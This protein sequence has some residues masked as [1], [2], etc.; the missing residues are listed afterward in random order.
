MS[1]KSF[2]W[3]AGAVALGVGLAATGWAG[4]P[5]PAADD[6][7]MNA[8][9]IEACSC[10]M[11]CQ[12]YFNTAP[13][14]HHEHSGETSHYCRFNNA[15]QVNKGHYGATDL[16]GARFWVAGD[17]GGDFSKGQ[18]DWAA[19]HFDPAVTAAQR[20]GIG[21]IVGY[22]YPVKWNSFAMGEDAAM[23]WKASK[24]RAE[25]RMDGGKKGEVVL[26]RFK[27]DTD[28]P[29]VIHN[30]HYW[31]VPRNEGF[32]LMP[33]EVEAYRAGAKPFE[34]KGTNGF[35]ITFDIASKDVA[36]AAAGK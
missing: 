31:G 8:S 4:D 20:A 32:V 15:F 12:C 9:I 16:A 3:L 7:H 29:V 23:E 35:M 21:K 18:M 24:D 30:L 10:P 19:L 36:P 26:N 13:A 33:N 34:Y 2:F 6:W 11:F 17:L 25:A 14:G 22:V 5:A 1:R 28:E 27:G